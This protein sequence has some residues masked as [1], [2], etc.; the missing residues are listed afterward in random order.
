MSYKTA[1]IVG[2][3]ENRPH[4]VSE[5]ICI[6]CKHRWIAVRLVNA[7][8]KN[9]ECPCC[10]KQGYVIETGEEFEELAR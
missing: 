3:E 9:L 6:N 4:K 10:H 8:L 2:I 1:K 5:V 7:K